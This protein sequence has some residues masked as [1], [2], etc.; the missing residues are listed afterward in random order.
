MSFR[1]AARIHNGAII[2]PRTPLTWYEIDDVIPDELAEASDPRCYYD[3]AQP[4]K[5]EDM[6]GAGEGEPDDDSKYPEG[7][8]SDDVSGWVLAGQDVGGRDEL[9]RRLKIAQD[10]EAVRAQGVRKGLSEFFG[11]V[12]EALAPSGE[13]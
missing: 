4:A 12:N 7:G 10:E 13:E 8:T 5:A 2:E 11:D 3:D 9:A 6:T 1:A